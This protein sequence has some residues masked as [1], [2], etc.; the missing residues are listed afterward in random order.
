MVGLEEI[1]FDQLKMSCKLCKTTKLIKEFGVARSGKISQVCLDCDDI[2]KRE[3]ERRYNSTPKRKLYLKDL[4]HR[5]RTLLKTGR[6]T[7]EEWTDIKQ[8]Q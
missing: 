6:V 4:K 3:Q 1:P 7:L 5:R 8:K 2:R